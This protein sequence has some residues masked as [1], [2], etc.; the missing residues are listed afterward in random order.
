MTDQEKKREEIPRKPQLEEIKKIKMESSNT[1]KEIDS[2][3]K[4]FLIKN[5]VGFNDKFY[6][7]PK[8]EISP[9]LHKFFQRTRKMNLTPHLIS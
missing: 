2:V 4:N 6:Q 1:L 3:I 7:I 8:E 5:Y 9:T